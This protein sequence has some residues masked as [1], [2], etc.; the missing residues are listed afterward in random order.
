M[1]EFTYFHFFRSQI[2]S[3]LRKFQEKL[4]RDSFFISEN[5]T[6]YVYKMQ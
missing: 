1:K 6:V 5:K 3:I 2:I 4:L